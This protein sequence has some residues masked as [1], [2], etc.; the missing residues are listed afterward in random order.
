[1][2]EK[3][4][5][6]GM[7]VEDDAI[8]WVI[9]LHSGKA[10]AQDLDQIRL[11]RARSARHEKAFRDA[12]TL[13]LDMGQAML[14]SGKPSPL[15]S[16]HRTS[17]NSRFGMPTARLR[18]LA[19]TTAILIFAL[20]GFRLFHL[21]DYWQADYYTHVGEQ[22]TIRLEDG[23]TVWLNTDTALQLDPNPK[24]RS[25]RLLH[26]QALFQVAPDPNR[27]FDVAAGDAVIRALG[28][29]FEVLA[30]DEQTTITVA[31]HAVAVTIP[32]GNSAP[33]RVIL[34]EGE[35]LSIEEGQSAAP[36][37]INLRQQLAWRRGKLIFKQR[38]LAE[39]VAEI[40]RYR[41]GKILI[42]GSRLRTLEVTGVFPLD[43][44]LS[45]MEVIQQSLQI[46][47]TRIGPWITLLHD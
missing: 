10:D 3:P 12:E 45:L 24:R 6:D 31:E 32:T 22:K 2:N 17:P 29:E 5:S 21:G 7:S 4:K 20:L 30:V 27:P 15:P 1:M 19:F 8:E 40:E 44:T 42:A 36:T 34:Q 23:S 38:S 13:W 28:T 25:L 26:G 9:L 46:H 11:W 43:D 18:T 14:A 47:A 33:S 37:R 41:H 39:V 16:E 35:K